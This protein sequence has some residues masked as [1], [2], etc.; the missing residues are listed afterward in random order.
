MPSSPG[1]LSVEYPYDWCTIHCFTT[2]C[3]LRC[4]QY[5]AGFIGC[6]YYNGSFGVEAIRQLQS[7]RQHCPQFCKGDHNAVFKMV[8]SASFSMNDVAMEA[9]RQLLGDLLPIAGYKSCKRS[10]MKLF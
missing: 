7:N 9:R 1:W 4:T 3:E 2:S 10:T 8:Q 5:Y 6:S